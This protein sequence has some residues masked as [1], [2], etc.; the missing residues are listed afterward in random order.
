MQLVSWALAF[1]SIVAPIVLG[2]VFVVAAGILF[3]RVRSV[4]T[5]FFFFGLLVATLASWTFQFGGIAH[6]RG[7][8]ILVTIAAMT[9]QIFG[10]L[11]YVLSV[12]KK[13]TAEN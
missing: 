6:F 8:N 4:A 7:M 12:P 10:F 9:I 13:R 5:A 3:A 2:L 1:F 11:F